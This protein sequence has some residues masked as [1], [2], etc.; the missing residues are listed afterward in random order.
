MRF[1]SLRFF[2]MGMLALVG[3]IF[4]AGGITAGQNGSR[5]GLVV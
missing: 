1:P 4:V 3:L 5:N 2:V